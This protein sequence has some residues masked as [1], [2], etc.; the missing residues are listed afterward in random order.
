MSGPA[1][2]RVVV[3]T[4]GGTGIG[5]A[6]A[7]RF[8]AEGASV[9]PVLGMALNRLDSVFNEVRRVARNLRP[10]LLDDLGLFAALQH[11]A[12]E[13]QAGSTLEIHVTQTG[14]PCELADEQ[15]TALFRI[16]QE[17]LTNVER[18]AHA[19]RV[20]VALAFE[21]KQTR[22]TV[23]DDGTGFDVA[24]MQSDPQRGIGL[25]NLRERM[26]AL[27]GMVRIGCGRDAADTAFATIY[28]QVTPKPI[29]VW[30]EAVDGDPSEPWTTDAVSVTRT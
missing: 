28:G 5:R 3:V 6:V 8:A 26:A 7:E 16:A 22:L 19:R 10:A 12:R 27:D 13:M 18:H 24:R 14:Q 2:E 11:L 25:R 17:A 15:A 9:A 23:R 1:A 21:D 29:R 30:S 4:G 20:E